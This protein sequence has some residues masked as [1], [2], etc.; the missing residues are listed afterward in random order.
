[1]QEPVQ[2]PVDD[3][4]ILRGEI[5]DM[6]AEMRRHMKEVNKTQDALCKRIEAL[7]FFQRGMLQKKFEDPVDYGVP[8]HKLRKH[9]V[10]EHYP[11]RLMT[12]PATRMRPLDQGDGG[13]EV[14]IM[15]TEAPQ[16]IP[17]G[18]RSRSYGRRLGE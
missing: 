4:H 11:G 16:L 1:M 17:V 18:S 5:Q 14:E 8:A 7:T 9:I 2:A 15:G 10:N 3:P 12:I 13:E 6:R